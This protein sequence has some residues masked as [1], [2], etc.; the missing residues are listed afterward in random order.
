MCS[1][2]GFQQGGGHAEHLALGLEL[3]EIGN[4][5]QLAQTQTRNDV[6]AK[7]G[8][9]RLY[10]QY[11]YH[12]VAVQLDGCL[13]KWENGLPNDWKLQNLPKVVDRTARAG[14]YLLHLR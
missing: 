11:E 5:I 8:L 7:L 1:S 3:H 2:G 14:R 9:P 13:N 12:T 4:H 6:T 10:Q